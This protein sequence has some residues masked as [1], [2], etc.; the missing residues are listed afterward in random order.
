MS[1]NACWSRPIPVLHGKERQ[2]LRTF[3]CPQ[4]KVSS[5]VTNLDA[6]YLLVEANC[7][8]AAPLAFPLLAVMIRHTLRVSRDISLTVPDHQG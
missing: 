3:L 1:L 2:T 7:V 8:F 6:A 5:P 4:I